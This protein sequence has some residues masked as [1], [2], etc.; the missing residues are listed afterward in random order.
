MTAYVQGLR[1]YYEGLKDGHYFGPHGQNVVS[2][3]TQYTPI[4]DP[5]V[6]ALMVPAGVDPNGYLN[7]KS[8]E[9]DLQFW[10]ELGSVKGTISAAQV[11]DLSFVDAANKTL[12]R[13]RP[14]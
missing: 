3:L 7:V 11:V 12:G 8:M 13:Y 2:I 9:K 6:Y 10:R 14:Q 5:A 4:K 1:Y